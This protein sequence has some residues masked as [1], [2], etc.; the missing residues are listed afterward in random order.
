[1]HNLPKILQKR[2]NF[3]PFAYPTA[4]EI[5]EKQQKAHWTPSEVEM[6][7]D[8]HQYHTEFSIKEKHAITTILKIFTQT[9]NIVADYWTNVVGRWFVQP[10][11]CMMANTFASF[12]AIHAQAYDKLNTALGLDSK[13][14]YLSFLED[15]ALKKKTEFI[16]SKMEIFSEKDLPLS[17]AVFSGFTEGVSLFSSFAILLNFQ[18]FNKL[19]DVANI[20]SWSI[21]DES[22][23]SSAGC[24]LFRTLVSEMNYSKEEL[25]ALEMQI[26]EVA[27]HI[28]DMEMIY[29]NKIFLEDEL[30][31]LNKNDMKNFIRHR[32][33]QKM[34]DL[35][36]NDIYTNLPTDKVGA[37][38]N[39]LNQAVEFV[40]FFEARSTNY[41]KGWNFG[42]INW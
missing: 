40:D 26:K 2:T 32:I 30:E 18:R 8:V 5:F 20:I 38:F 13:E 10:E 22:L 9:E 16:E 35:G 6:D 14:F 24:W 19:K 4:F 12:E 3:R 23:H 42:H 37:W 28:H 7:A 29:I 21:R 1:M 31:G 36:F 27:E 33:N 41:V 25:S 15:E 34:R 17:L 39:P 11:I